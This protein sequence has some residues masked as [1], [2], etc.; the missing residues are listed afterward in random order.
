MIFGSD[1]TAK[2]KEFDK[3]LKRLGQTS[4]YSRLGDIMMFAPFF[5]AFLSFFIRLEKGKRIPKYAP[6]TDSEANGQA[7]R[8]NRL[9]KPT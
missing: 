7:L 2:D 3:L 4:W 1:I 8:I 5:E 6:Q 9:Q